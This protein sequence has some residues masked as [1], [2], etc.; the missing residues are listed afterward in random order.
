MPLALWALPAGG[1]IIGI[2]GTFI[3]L[4]I[5]ENSIEQGASLPAVIMEQSVYLLLPSLASLLIAI[6][7][8]RLAR[9]TVLLG[10]SAIFSLGLAILALSRSADM[11]SISFML[12]AAVYILYVGASSIVAAESACP[13]KHASALAL[14]FS[15]PILGSVLAYPLFLWW[16]GINGGIAIVWIM[17]ALGAAALIAIAKWVPPC[18]HGQPQNLS[19][20]IR[21]LG[22]L[23]V[24]LSF[25][26]TALLSSGLAIVSLSIGELLVKTTGFAPSSVLFVM[27]A[28]GA[29]QI[30]GNFYGGKLADKHLMPALV[31]NLSVLAITQALL[32]L[33]IHGKSVVV[34]MYALSGAAAY[35]FAPSQQRRILAKAGEAPVLASTVNVA[36]SCL[37]SVAGCWLL[38]PFFGRR[39]GLSPAPLM[40]A[41]I[42]TIGLLVALYSW[43]LERRRPHLY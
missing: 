23:Q 21:A 37:G 33:A 9:K 19:G 31:A 24:L 22:R 25:A 35:A 29:F 13:G 14:V 28:F 17:A 11:L 3:G 42:T 36:A 41:G 1:F 12:Y 18:R 6:S 8:T 2:S 38:L 32:A 26:M 7:T 20:N 5:M 34:I 39:E 43:R 16:M 30:I 10:L 15:G 27:L 4:S 40:A